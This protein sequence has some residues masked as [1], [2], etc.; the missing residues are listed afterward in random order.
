M[1]RAQRQAAAA[2]LGALGALSDPVRQA[3]YAH[4]ANSAEPVSRDGAASAVGISRALAAFHLEKL[5][6]AR[7]LRGEFE[8]ARLPRR[9]RPRK[10]Y[11]AAGDLSITMPPRNYALVGRILG[12]A[13]TARWR[14]MRRYVA[15]AA[16]EHGELLATA[17]R[18]RAGTHAT[19]AR[20]VTA[21]RTELDDLGYAPHVKGDTITLR[22]CPYLALSE[23]QRTAVCHLNCEFL[24]GLARS[25]D[26]A[27]EV[28]P[29]PAAPAAP[30]GCCAALRLRG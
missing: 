20:L 18:H 21:L 13:V 28:V 30:E 7:L 8:R 3:L 12:R 19:R 4:V 16:R 27:V 14:S 1:K 26:A 11:R 24:G 25:F 9:G 2:P 15:S 17:A 10:L 22:N 23:E 5:V 6:R 29:H